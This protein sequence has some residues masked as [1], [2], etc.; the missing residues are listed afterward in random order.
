MGFDV[1]VKHALNLSDDDYYK[2]WI[3]FG[4]KV[5]HTTDKKFFGVNGNT[6]YYRW[7]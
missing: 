6:V 1:S 7:K 3:A 2:T 4:V 5:E